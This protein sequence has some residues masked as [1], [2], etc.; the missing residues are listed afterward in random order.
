[1]VLNVDELAD[2]CM[3]ATK[4]AFKI[5]KR[6][7]TNEL[8]VDSTEFGTR[9]SEVQILSPRPNILQSINCGVYEIRVRRLVHGRVRET[10]T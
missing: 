4:F 1:M 6:Y 8:A 3:G 5:R 7:Q 2:G 10:T 9:G